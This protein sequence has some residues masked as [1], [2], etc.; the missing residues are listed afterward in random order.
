MLMLDSV[1]TSSAPHAYY[2]LSR[3][4]IHYEDCASCSG[5]QKATMSSCS[6]SSRFSDS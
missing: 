5:N 4:S 1:L 3:V 2:P 6:K